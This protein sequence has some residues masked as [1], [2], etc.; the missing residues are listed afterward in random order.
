MIELYDEFGDAVLE[1]LKLGEEILH[2]T[3]QV[4]TFKNIIYFSISNILYKLTKKP[5]HFDTS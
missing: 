1:G 2:A 4:L 5:I 3:I